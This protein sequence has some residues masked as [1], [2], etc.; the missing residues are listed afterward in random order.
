MT[1]VT[2]IPGDGIGPEVAFAAKDVVDATGV[3]IE[4]DI[5]NAGAD[6]Y[7]KTGEFIPEALLKS[8][9]KNRVVLKGPITT[10]IGKGF[11]SINVTL[12]QKFDT[13]ANIR[14]LKTMPGTKGVFENVDLVV[15]RE[16]TEGLYMGI[17]HRINEDV[18]EAIK[19]IT[20][21]GSMRIAEETFKYAKEKGR[22]KVTAVHKANIMKITDGLFLDC[23]RKVSKDYPD[24]EYEEKIVDNMCMQ[25]VMYPE[26][27]DVLVMPNLYGDILSDL[28]SGL[29]G[30]LGLVPGANIGSDIGI[31]EAVHGSAPDIA[32]K[33]LANPI[34]CIM[35]STM[36]LDY[37]G[38]RERANRIR[39][40]VWSVLKEGRHRTKDLGG[41]A[42]TEEITK[43]ICEKI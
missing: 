28:A 32:G 39:K 20:R 15:F 14:P 5:V 27:Y 42:R 24:I 41:N 4:W 8:I 3:D 19:V 18:A 21:K 16:N 40:A 34:A 9:E 22:K 12:R 37:I 26:R 13:Y 35:S 23:T 31:F 38:E 43:A 10:P 6:I 1:K 25:L 11:R 2:L 36:M 30:G 17:E 7:E 29:V 33:S